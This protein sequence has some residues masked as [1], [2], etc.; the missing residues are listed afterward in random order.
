[1]PVASAASQG[2]PSA[3]G[4]GVTNR[5]AAS[6][7]GLGMESVAWRNNEIGSPELYAGWSRCK[8]H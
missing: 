8:L 3:Y 5:M 6:L 2:M 1:M 7:H 4:D